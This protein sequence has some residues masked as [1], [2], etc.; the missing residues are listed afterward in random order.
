VGKP[1]QILGNPAPCYNAGM[2]EGQDPLKAI[3]DR[4]RK[5]LRLAAALSRSRG[6]TDVDPQDILDVI[7]HCGSVADAALENTEYCKVALPRD[8]EP[9]DLPAVARSKALLQIV[10]EAC[11]EAQSCGHTWVG[12]EHILF[13]LMRIYPQM[14]PN[15]ELVG[16]EM[17]RFLGEGL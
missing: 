11:G 14:I 5:T 7:S 15:A 17:L 13:A 1:G 6:H 9:L 4:T 16:A 12:T 8:L 3:T 10:A 2:S